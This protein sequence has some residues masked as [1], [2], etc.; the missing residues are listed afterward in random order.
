MSFGHRPWLQQHWDLRAAA[1]FVLGGTGA[2]LLLGWALLSP[3]AQSPDWRG[4]ALAGIALI[5]AGLGAV[6]LEIGRKLRAVNVLFNPGTSWMSRE[7]YV[8]VIVFALVVAALALDAPGWARAGAF[9]ALVFL[10]CQARILRASKG[11]PAWRLAQ[12]VPLI[13]TTGLAEGVGL[14]L[15][16]RPEPL[17][18]AL[19]GLLVI[20]RVFAWSRYRMALQAPARQ[21]LE[22][23]GKSLVQL[24]TVVPLVLCLASYFVPYAAVLAGIAAIAT[25]WQLKVVLVT[26]A[27]YNQGFALPRLPVR[28]VR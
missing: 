22:D 11:I 14:Y 18:A 15:V 20:A 16:V 28:G 21:A 7:A 13:V 12:V 2:G 1:N 17:P 5:A 4:F 26:R 24:G 10:W 3:A 9:A 6:W 19:L 25:G 23:A 27:A 8:A